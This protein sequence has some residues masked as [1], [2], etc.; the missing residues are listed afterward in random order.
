MKSKLKSVM[1]EKKVTVRELQKMSGVSLQTI[2]KACDERINTCS[3]RSIYS[4]AKALEVSIVDLI[5]EEP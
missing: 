5:E 1:K 4:I 3:V 2:T